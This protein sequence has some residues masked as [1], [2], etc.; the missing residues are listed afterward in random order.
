MAITNSQQARQMYN[1]G[2]MGYQDPRQRYGLGSFVKKAV[3][4]IKKVAKSPLGKAALM[5]AATA[6]LG[7]LGAGKG[8]LSKG[9]FSPSMIGKNIGSLGRFLPGAPITGADAFTNSRSTVGGG[10][11][12]S[13]YLNP[14]N[15]NN[16]L[17]YTN[18]A[19]SGNKAFGLG[20]AFALGAPLIQNA[21]SKGEEVVEEVDED[22]I[23]PY[24]AMM[25]AKFKNPQMNFLPENR[26]TNNYYQTAVPAANGGRIGYAD[27]MMVEDEEDFN[28]GLPS[29]LMDR[30]GYANGE[31]V[32]ESVEEVQLPDEAEQMLQVEYKKYLDGGGQLP[33]PEFKKLVLQQM[34]DEQEQP[35]V[36]ETMM[37]ENVSMEG[38]PPAQGIAQLAMGGTA[39]PGYGTPA[40]TN[41]FGYPSGGVRVGAEEG[42]MMN[43][44]GMEKDYRA[45]GG[46]VPIG[47]KEKA[48]DVPARLSVNEFVF[49]ADAVRNAGGG[50]IDK[51][52]EVMEN[53]MNNL[54]NGGQVSEDSQGL[55]GAQQMY[56]Q[57]Q[58]LQSRMA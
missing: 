12:F 54:E 29:R 20:S 27:G 11:F 18:Q 7:S 21:L 25:M 19:F 40:G 16:P 48:D 58:M 56:D 41:Q 8:F 2:G 13:K 44:G 35:Q 32:Q 47:K 28:L 23:D 9:M 26:F 39:V 50:D 36:D 57:Q 6:G 42:G 45:E 30:R 22:Y 52:A 38:Q 43:L 55:E 17:L 49:T 24:T 1:Q 34:K 51:G 15:K 46:F 37:A 3:R 14:F 33:Y 4:G 10:N 31:M 5:Y 53:M